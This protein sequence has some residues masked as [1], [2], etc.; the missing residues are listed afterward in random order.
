[1]NAY[2]FEISVSVNDRSII[3]SWRL[4]ELNYVTCVQTH[5]PKMVAKVTVVSAGSQMNTDYILRYQNESC[6]STL[7]LDAKEEI[8]STPEIRKM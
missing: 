5:I 1:L 4:K 7:F 3:F 2:R 8:Y 6:H